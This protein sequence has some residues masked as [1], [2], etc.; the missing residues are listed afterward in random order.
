MLIRTPP[1]V[2]SWPPWY[3]FTRPPGRQPS[4]R[5][6]DEL[7]LATPSQRASQIRSGSVEGA[8]PVDAGVVEHLDAGAGARVDAGD[9][10]ELVQPGGPGAEE[11]QRGLAAV[12]VG[13]VEALEVVPERAAA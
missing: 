10:A 3:C 1:Q 5:M 13:V 8:G 4:S 12:R 11:R 2:S 7:V 6:Y 9:V